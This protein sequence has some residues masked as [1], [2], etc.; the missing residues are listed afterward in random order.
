MGDQ[1]NWEYVDFFDMPDKGRKLKCKD[2]K[3]VGYED[4]EF[5]NKYCKW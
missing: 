2:C 3:M 5:Y 1:H 4:E